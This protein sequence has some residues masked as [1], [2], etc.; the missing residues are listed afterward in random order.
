MHV[1][2]GLFLDIVIIIGAAFLGGLSARIV[3]L[4]IL[5]GYLV[6]GIIIGPHGLQIIGGLQEVQTVA[7]FGVILLLFAIGIEVS[8]RE[9]RDLGKSIIIIAIGQILVTIGV[10]FVIGILIG[11]IPEQALVFGLV[12]S[13]SS[14]M[15]VLKTLS[16][17]GELRSLH[18]R[19]LTGILLIQDLAFIPMIA[20]LPAL[21]GEGDRLLLDIGIGI[22]K[23]AV[24]LVAIVLL[25]G[26]I[27]PWLMRRVAYLGSR[28]VFILML[29]A[30]IFII[31]AITQTAGL[32]AALGAFL[33]G[34]LL[35]ESE[36][37]HRA[38]S[39][40]VPFRDIFASLFFVSLGM[41][42]IP[43]FLVQ[44]YQLVLI[45]VVATIL[46]K[47]AITVGLVRASGYLAHTAIFS[48]LGLVQ[49]GEFSFIIAGTAT[50]LGIFTN[51]FLS[52]TVVSAVLTMAMTPG[53]MAGGSRALGNLGQRFSFLGRYPLDD[54]N[55]DE[56]NVPVYGH[57]VICGLGRVG[58]LI[59]HALDEHNLPYVVIDLDPHVASRH[60]DGGGRVIHGSSASD[61]ILN[62]AHVKDA[63]LM[64]ICT[65]DPAATYLTA[66]R[67]LQI[68]PNLDIV[69]RAY[70]REEGDRLQR[71]G[72]QEVVWPAMEGGLEML[73]HSLLR[74]RFDFDEVNSLIGGLRSHLSLGDE[75][76]SEQALPPE[77]LSEK[78]E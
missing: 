11:W 28:E 55:A 63:G 61:T 50:T 38:L 73:R 72:V 3:R 34:L 7:E 27:V 30:A 1:E 75:P 16:D 33:A 5:L 32:S 23:A 8:F 29:L 24:V 67:A 78:P 77:S 6:A 57:A 15:V 19:I 56:Q 46:V 35:S 22:G 52:L 68:N 40:V 20:I 58:S 26:R 4:P 60:R 65:G 62:A 71:L 48:G 36:F 18:G 66:Q 43:I 10:A 42:V 45:V 70:W 69:A 76:E 12:I 51:D 13:L 9:L 14:T 47:F 21:S 31:A 59:A 25:G 2:T 17:R 53:I 37:G 41:L 49:I 39:E 44:N 54:N 64:V 74:Y